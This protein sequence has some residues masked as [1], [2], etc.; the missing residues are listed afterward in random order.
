MLN[1]IVDGQPVQVKKGSTILQA[2]GKL[3]IEVPTLCYLKHLTPEGACRICA[4]EVKGVKNLQ[5]SCAALCSE[6]MEVTT[7]NERI[8]AFRRIVI[9]LLLANHD[10]DCFSCSA[11]GRCELYKLAMDYG[12]ERSRFKRTKKARPKDESS[13]F[14]NYDPAKCILCRRCVRT[15]NEIQSNRT[16]SLRDRGV[17]TSVSL[18]FGKVFSDSNC[19]SCGNCVSACPTGALTTKASK[20]YRIWEVT[21][22]RTTCPYCGVGCQMDLLVKDGKVVGVEPADGEANPGILC[23]KGK[24]AYRFI[25]HPDRLKTPLIRK[26]GVLEPATWD[27]TLNYVADGIKR[28]KEESGP[29]AIAGFASARATNEDN[30][31]FMKMMRAAIGTNNV[32]HCARL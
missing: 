10:A 15:C 13:E 22:T 18:P 21:R 31:V 9:E 27:E 29:D 17:R 19:V 6:G 7:I 28:I 24:F 5:F 14:F 32:D 3:G 4:V 23:V 25:G 16:L 2:C 30:Y 12:V 11:V 20:H 26:D 1:V 8:A